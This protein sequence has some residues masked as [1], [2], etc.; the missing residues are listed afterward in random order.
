MF[1]LVELLIAFIYQ[2]V[3]DASWHFSLKCLNEVLCPLQFDREGFKYVLS[4]LLGKIQKR[5][6]KR[7]VVSLLFFFLIANESIGFIDGS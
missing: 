2:I 3:S 5:F 1:H 7:V 6:P 4:F